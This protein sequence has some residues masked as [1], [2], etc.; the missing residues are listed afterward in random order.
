MLGHCLEASVHPKGS[1]TGQLDHGFP[2]FSLV[3]EQMLSWYPNCHVALLASHAALPIGKV[4]IS[5]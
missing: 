4:E 5:P 1:A 3:P 2:W